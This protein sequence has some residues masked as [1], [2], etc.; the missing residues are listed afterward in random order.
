MLLRGLQLCL[1]KML[2]FVYV[3]PGSD[4]KEMS[5]PWLGASNMPTI[6][7]VEHEP[8][9]A[10][11]SFAWVVDYTVFALSRLFQANFYIEGISQCVCFLLDINL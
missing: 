2:A 10:K 5:R 1:E 11:L 6:H 3:N 4:V 9:G 8:H 7:H